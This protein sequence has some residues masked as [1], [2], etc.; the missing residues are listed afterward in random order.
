MLI[1]PAAHEALR[2]LAAIAIVDGDVRH[3]VDTWLT[4][5]FFNDARA[6]SGAAWDAAITDG[7]VLNLDQAIAYA[8]G[9]SRARTVR[10]AELEW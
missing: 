9:E 10:S 7:T 6:R 2:G 8:V 4:S 3:A 1:Q 5:T